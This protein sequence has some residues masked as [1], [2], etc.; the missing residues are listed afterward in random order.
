VPRRLRG[1]IERASRRLREQAGRRV[2][3]P[4]SAWR[5]RD[6]LRQAAMAEAGARRAKRE[7]AERERLS[8]AQAAWYARLR[9]AEPRE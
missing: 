8:A 3:R 2:W 4:P 5:L 9:D 1:A 6:G 7:I